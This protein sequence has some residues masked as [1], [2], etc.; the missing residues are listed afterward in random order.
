MSALPT[1]IADAVK[2][3]LLASGLLPDGTAVRS[4]LYFEDD[5]AALRELTVLVVPMQS[6]SGWDTRASVDEQ[7]EI[8]V[9]VV[10]PCDATDRAAIDGRLALVEAVRRRLAAQPMASCNPESVEQP[11]VLDRGAMKTR[12]QFFT[13]LKVTYTASVPLA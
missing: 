9:A 6:T 7:H 13:F 5:L 8:H 12:N 4:E 2:A 1:Q 11:V 10:A 3:D